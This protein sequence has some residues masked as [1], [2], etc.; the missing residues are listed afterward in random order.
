MTPPDPSSRETEA[1]NEIEQTCLSRSLACLLLAIGL[2]PIFCFWTAELF[3]NFAGRSEVASRLRAPLAARAADLLGWNR[4]LRRRFDELEAAFD[5]HSSLARSVRPWGQLLLAAALRYGN[6]ESYLAR[7]GPIL[8]RKDFE[9]AT[10]RVAS[11]EM[12]R[13]TR[14][15]ESILDLQDRLAALR[16]RLLVVAVPVKPLFVLPGTGGHTR[17]LA[18]WRP[19]EEAFFQRLRS[20]G[21][22]VLDLAHLLA[23]LAAVERPFL[24]T[25]T[26][27]TPAAVDCVAREIALRLREA[28][29][30]PEGNPALFSIGSE[31]RSGLGDG[32]RQLDLP[33]SFRHRWAETVQVETVRWHDG[34]LLDRARDSPVLLIGDSFAAVYSNPLLHFGAAAGLA[35]RLSYQ[36]GLPIESWIE[37][38]ASA[39]SL[40]RK[41]ENRMVEEPARFSSTRAVVLVFSL[42]TLTEPS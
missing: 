31:K 9:H 14:I 40:V 35:E 7:S 36:L 28:V 25:D 38:G 8:Y 2:V 12:E 27:W 39:A 13:A 6:E 26:H 18:S 34:A 22:E 20:R 10:G 37:T 29:P 32:V 24:L 42:R 17:N 11:V 15:A 30:L 1:R 23:L 33:L 16:V 5:Q 3:A 21:A 19:H 41:L 4:E